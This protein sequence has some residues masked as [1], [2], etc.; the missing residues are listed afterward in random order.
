MLRTFQSGIKTTGPNC[1]P[2]PLQPAEQHV[3]TF[4]LN[5]ICG[6]G[7][8]ARMISE[9]GVNAESP[10]VPRAG[11]YVTVHNPLCQRSSAVR[12][13]VVKGIETAAEIKY[14]D[15]LVAVHDESTRARRHVRH[16]ADRRETGRHLGGMISDPW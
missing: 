12:T 7:V 1:S 3:L 4:D 16:L 2:T 5:L 13:Y 8:A 6:D 15:G 9:T 14:R 11:N 10:T